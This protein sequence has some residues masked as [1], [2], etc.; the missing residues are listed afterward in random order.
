MR[1]RA[2][3]TDS[4]DWPLILLASVLIAVA[5]FGRRYLLPRR[6]RPAYAPS[7]R[8]LWTM[9]GGC[10]VPAEPDLDT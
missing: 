10:Y 4:P 7:F 1:R 9:N 2:R 8:E 6:P 3:R 5:W